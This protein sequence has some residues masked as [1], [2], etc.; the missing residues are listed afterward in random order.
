MIAVAI[1]PALFLCL[2]PSPAPALP[3]TQ[4]EPAQEERERADKQLKT[5][6]S[7]LREQSCP[8]CLSLAASLARAY[9]STLSSPFFFSRDARCRF[10]VSPFVH[11]V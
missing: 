8:L 1:A 3:R 2:A 10:S 4:R 11:L 5:L 7:S 6:P 9:L